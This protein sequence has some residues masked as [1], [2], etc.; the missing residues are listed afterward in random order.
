MPIAPITGKLRKTLIT[1]IAI[2]FGLGIGGGYAYWYGI[3]VPVEQKRENL[4]AK[5]AREKQQKQC[6]TSLSN[7]HTFSDITHVKRK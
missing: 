6:T 4:Y 7:T 1:D 3:H 2:A 5:L